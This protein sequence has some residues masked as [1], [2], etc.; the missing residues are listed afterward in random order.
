MVDMPGLLVVQ[1]GDPSA[2]GALATSPFGFHLFGLGPSEQAES[3]SGASP[4]I[5]RARIMD[6]RMVQVL[7]EYSLVHKLLQKLV[8][9]K[10][11]DISLSSIM[12][13]AFAR[14]TCA[15]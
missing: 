15:K 6:Q 7:K 11:N 10:K 4:I 2:A 1:G 13:V 14:A 5:R 8:D 3:K 9:D 12:C